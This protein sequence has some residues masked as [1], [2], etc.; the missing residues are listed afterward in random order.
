MTDNAINSVLY[1]IDQTSDTTA[2]EKARA[3]ANI[4]AQ[5]ALTAGDNVSIV[6]DTISAVDTKYNVFST[7]ADGLVPKASGTGDTGKFLKGDGTWEAIS[8]S[9]N[10]SA[11]I[12]GVGTQADPLVLRI[13][14][15]LSLVQ[16]SSDHITRLQVTHPVPAPGSTSAGK[17]LTC[18]DALE[19]LSW[20]TPAAATGV[21]VTVTTSNTYAEVTAILTGGNE[22]V[23]SVADANG[24]AFYRRVFTG[25]ITQ[26]PNPITAVKFARLAGSVFEMYTIDSDT[27]NWVYSSVPLTKHSHTAELYYYNTDDGDHYH[28]R[29]IQNYAINHVTVENHSADIC[30]IVVEAPTLGT[31]EE[32]DYNIVFDC[33]NSSGGCNVSVQGVSP[34]IE[35]KWEVDYNAVPLKTFAEDITNC[36]VQFD[37]SFGYQINVLG[38]AWKLQRF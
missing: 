20:Q 16:N 35:T 24:A 3:R 9:V 2:D 25:P 5:G 10:A 28:I 23:L 26:T 13:S 18:N 17:V 34:E 1:N 11:P 14:H 29:G 19:N 7:T 8:T 32:Y 37:N 4:G 31:N 36:Y 21:Q 27:G 15:G 12:Y 38:R 33:V 6:N 22:P 30:S